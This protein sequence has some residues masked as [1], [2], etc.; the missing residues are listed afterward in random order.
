M[1]ITGVW[2]TNAYASVYMDTWVSDLTEHI[3]NK[4]SPNYDLSFEIDNTLLILI[5]LTDLNSIS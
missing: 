4:R 1:A 3:C 2:L 5:L